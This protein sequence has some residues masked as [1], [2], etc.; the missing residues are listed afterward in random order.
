MLISGKSHS[1]DES[2]NSWVSI[3][4]AR[5]RNFTCVIGVGSPAEARRGRGDH[6]PYPAPF[7][8]DDGTPSPPADDLHS[9][10]WRAQNGRGEGYGGGDQGSAPAI[11]PRTTGR[12]ITASPSGRTPLD[13][14]STSRVVWARETAGSNRLSSAVATCQKADVQRSATEGRDRR[15]DAGVGDH[16]RSSNDLAHH[17]VFWVVTKWAKVNTTAGALMRDATICR[18]YTATQRL[19]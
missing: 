14:R 15:P 11:G 16:R 19:S 12:E 2:R 1:R 13:N 7:P 10:Q 18:L 3:D 9:R 6:R 8:A 17:I 4:F 5:V